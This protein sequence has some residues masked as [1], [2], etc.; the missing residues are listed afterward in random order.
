MTQAQ[1]G[2]HSLGGDDNSWFKISPFINA[3]DPKKILLRV[4]ERYGGCIPL[5]MSSERIFFLS[6][7]DH[8]RRVLVGNVDNHA[9]SFDDLKPTFGN[10]M[11]TILA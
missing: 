9:K 7:T 2:I 10:A 3:D 4:N 11:I 1:D 8:I 6:D 5:N